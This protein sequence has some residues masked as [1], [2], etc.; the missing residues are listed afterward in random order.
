MAKK[1]FELII[2]R[3]S[4]F[5]ILLLIL[6][7]NRCLPLSA[8]LAIDW[9]KKSD[10]LG[11]SGVPLRDAHIALDVLTGPFQLADVAGIQRGGRRGFLGV[12]R[13]S[14]TELR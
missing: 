12:V 13:D 3:N 1:S 11:F 5:S 8:F 10:E 7:S 4:A 9:D 6:G 14:G 2:S